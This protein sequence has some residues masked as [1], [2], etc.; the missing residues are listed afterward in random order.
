M[1][2]ATLTQARSISSHPHLVTLNL[3]WSQLNIT[4]RRKWGENKSVIC[5]HHLLHPPHPHLIPPVYSQSLTFLWD[6]SSQPRVVMSRLVFSQAAAENWMLSV[7][8]ELHT[9]AWIINI[10]ESVFCPLVE[11]FGAEGLF[12]FNKELDICGAELLH[13][14]IH[15]SPRL[16]T[17]AVTGGI[18]VTL[19]QKC[20]K[21]LLTNR[22]SNV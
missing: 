17:Q 19:L 4:Y 3:F 1:G 16:L 14:D 7:T 12:F 21:A 22:F 18:S 2:S 9:R 13:L 5:L 6:T 20:N 10:V 15:S 8:D 11:H